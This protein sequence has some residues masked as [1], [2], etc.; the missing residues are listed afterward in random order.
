MTWLVEIYYDYLDD[1]WCDVTQYKFA[2]KELA[3]E[4]IKESEKQNDVFVYDET[5]S[6]KNNLFFS[7]IISAGHYQDNSMQMYHC[8]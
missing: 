3:D 6:Y 7:K 1:E 5:E 4:F 8:S 2:T